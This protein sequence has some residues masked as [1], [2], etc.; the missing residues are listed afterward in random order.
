MK[1][2]NKM[3]RKYIWILTWLGDGGYPELLEYFT[4]FKKLKKY[5]KIN[6]VEEYEYID[7]DKYEDFDEYF[8]H[9]IFDHHK[10]LCTYGYKKIEIDKK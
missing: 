1:K 6:I 7:D 5:I 3:S 4:S 2:I 8:N 9:N 10:D